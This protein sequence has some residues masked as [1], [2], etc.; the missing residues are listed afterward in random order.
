[1][2]MEKSK[3]VTL[4]L[5]EACN[6]KCVYCY[7]AFKSPRTM[8]F[9]TAVAILDRELNAEDDFDYVE[10]AFHGGE[11]MLEYDL[12]RSICEY[13]WAHEYRHKYYFF[14]TTNGT[15]ITEERRRW[16]LENRDRII[17][18]LSLDGT[19]LVHNLNRSDSYDRICIPFF[20]TAWP[21]QPVKMTLSRN[22]MLYLSES[23]IHI[24]SLGFRVLANFAF[25]V[26]WKEEFIVNALDDA[27]EKLM[28]YYMEHPETE[29]CS[30]LNQDFHM[31]GAQFKRWCGAGT[32]MRVYDVSGKVYP[33]HFF[34]GFAIGEEKACSAEKID[35]LNDD[36]FT[37][38]RCKSC[39]LLPMCP[40]C[41][42]FNFAATGNIAKRD[43]G[44]CVLTQ[45]CILAAS[46]LAYKRLKAFD[47]GTLGITEEMRNARLRGIYEVQRHFANQ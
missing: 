16:F 12:L 13:A 11:P 9:E 41:Y 46:C 36:L 7:E 45:H 3:H 21:N 38:E 1:M 28:D 42:G 6:L 26:D 37:D 23:V 27:L 33:C 35:F 15:L 43:E 29:I 34:Q 31:I 30:L 40:T 22:S 39:P 14:A 2:R 32:S 18:G 24:H 44:M 47:N 10:V 19:P 17:L 20:K 4:T 5:T 8:L 25:S